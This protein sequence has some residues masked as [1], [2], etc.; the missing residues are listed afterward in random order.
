MYSTPKMD[1]VSSD[2]NELETWYFDKYLTKGK[3]KK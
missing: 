1:T 2:N 3:D